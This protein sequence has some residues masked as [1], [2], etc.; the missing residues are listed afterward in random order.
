M[1][2]IG[3]LPGRGEIAKGRR[4]RSQRDEAGR[5]GEQSREGTGMRGGGSRWRNGK[6]IRRG[7]QHENKEGPLPGPSH[8]GSYYT[9]SER[10][11]WPRKGSNMEEKDGATFS[12]MPRVHTMEN[13]QLNVPAPTYRGDRDLKRKGIRTCAATWK[14]LEA[15]CSVK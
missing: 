1:G 2:P 6:V 5:E 7:G 3:E 9:K 14:T 13:S 15:S 11:D 8:S 12:K 4:R 10:G